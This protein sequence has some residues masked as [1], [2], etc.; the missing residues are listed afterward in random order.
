[1]LWN[2]RVGVRSLMIQVFCSRGFWIHGEVS[3]ASGCTVLGAF[4]LCSM[5]AGAD[6]VCGLCLSSF[7]A[8][9]VGTGL[10]ELSVL[11]PSYVNA[12]CL[13]RARHLGQ[14]WPNRS[15]HQHIV[16]SSCTRKQG[17]VLGPNLKV[18]VKA[19][20]KLGSFQLGSLP[21]GSY[22]VT[23]RNKKSLSERCGVEYG[24]YSPQTPINGLY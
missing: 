12:R 21:Q 5:W 8:A 10:L 17:L 4:P 19:L 14:W 11:S 18:R 1:M 13:P 9:K 16:K 22:T 15:L 2:F 3:T 20:S 7:S 24:N 6:R 23:R